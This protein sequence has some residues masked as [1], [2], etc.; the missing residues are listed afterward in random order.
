[1][2]LKMSRFTRTSD[3][4]LKIEECDMV[5]FVHKKPIVEVYDVEK[6]PLGRSVAL[7]FVLF[8]YNVFEYRFIVLNI[9]CCRMPQER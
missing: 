3:G 1:M 7:I 2:I 9:I 6:I 4:L 8:D 5:K